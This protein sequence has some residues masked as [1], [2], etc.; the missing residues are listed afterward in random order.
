MKL[1]IYISLI[2]LLGISGCDN[3]EYSPNQA[4]D[5]NT[6]TDLNN[7]NLDK[8][9]AAP[10]DDT[11]RFVVAGD[12]QRQY[13]NTR[14]L[15]NT[16]NKIPNIDMLLL[17]GDISEFGLLE[18]M[19]QINELLEKLTIPYITVVG[20]HDFVGNGDQVFKRMFGKLNFSFVYHGT[21][22]I[23]HNTNSREFKFNGRVPDL[24][25][26]TEEF[27]PEPGVDNYV[28][29]AHILPLSW[30]F[31]VSLTEQY[32]NVINGNPK[33]RAAFYAHDHSYSIHYPHNQN[34]PYVVTN[35]MINREFLLVEIINGTLS[36][37]NIKY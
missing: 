27:L 35:A 4:F 17:A 18:E 20:N 23:C 8:L 36:Y 16:V 7:K 1:Y 14:D 24:N 9:F 19:E 34:I 3:L 32:I 26:L 21:K 6:P 30:D 15:V 11:I 25:W 28:A 31:D 13:K 22:F 29:I 33:T 10:A 5:K 2:F 12:T 37:K